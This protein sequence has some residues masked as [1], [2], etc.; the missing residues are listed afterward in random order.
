[1]EEPKTLWNPGFIMILSFGFLNGTANQMVNPQLS[2]YAVS[3]GANLTL[4][5]TLVG[6]QSLIA[7]FLRPISG[8]V[9]DVLNRKT[10]RR[11]RSYRLQL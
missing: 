8:A 1:V 9:N 3:L 11:L 10:R 5:G 2:A 7:M 4:A 6:M